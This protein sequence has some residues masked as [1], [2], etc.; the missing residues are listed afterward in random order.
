M[1]QI[2]TRYHMARQNRYLPVDIEFYISTRKAMQAQKTLNLE[3][4][5]NGLLSSSLKKARVSKNEKS[6]SLNNIT[7]ICTCFNMHHQI[8]SI[9]QVFY[10]IMVFF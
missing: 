6:S 8:A 2:E 1:N 7:K 3:A 4:F 5:R 9:N 10:K